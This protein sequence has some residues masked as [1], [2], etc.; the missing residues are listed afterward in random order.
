MADWLRDGVKPDDVGRMVLD[1][2]RGDR[3]YVHTDRSVADQIAQR[4]DALLQAM[5]VA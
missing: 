2:V 3:L 4:C 1:A 5:P